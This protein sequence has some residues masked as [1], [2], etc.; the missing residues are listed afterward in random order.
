VDDAINKIYLISNQDLYFVFLSPKS[1]FSVRRYASQ[2]AFDD[3]ASE[4]ARPPLK[5]ALHS[6]KS[7][8]IVFWHGDFVMAKYA[9]TCGDFP[10][11]RSFHC[12][13]R[14]NESAR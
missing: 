3:S 13:I 8:E 9:K 14:L 11:L 6:G 2:G 10:R 4:P 12:V 1:P 5:N 7:K